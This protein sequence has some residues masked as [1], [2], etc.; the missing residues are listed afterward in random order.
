M[1]ATAQIDL[2]VQARNGLYAATGLVLLAS[3]A[4]LATLPPTGLARLLPAVAMQ[5]LGVTAFFFSAAL[6]LLERSEGSGSARAVTP[7]RPG[8]YLGARVATLGLLAAVQHLV[9]GALLVGPGPGLLPLTAGVVLG[10]AILSLAGFTLAAGRESLGAFLLPAVPWLALLLAPMLADALEWHYPLLW[11]HPLQGP[12]ALMRAAVTPA[13]PWEPPLALALGLGWTGV[14]FA[15]A[16]R[17][18]GRVAN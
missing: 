12:L 8:E 14:T 3:V 6:A 1:L 15:L 18:Y 7:L 9:L 11:L 16:R 5:N 2:E 10:S 17:A 4:A 13:P